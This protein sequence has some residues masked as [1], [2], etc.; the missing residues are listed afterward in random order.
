MCNAF[1]ITI[2]ALDAAGVM[3][4]RV[5]DETGDADT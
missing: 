4:A 2:N 1:N 5:D 3:A